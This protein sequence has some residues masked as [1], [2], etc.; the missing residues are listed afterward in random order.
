MF[1]LSFFAATLAWA[2]ECGAI[3]TEWL[4]CAKTRDCVII[5]DPC[6]WPKS[7]TN[8][9]FSAEA[10]KVN[11]CLA[12][13]LSCPAW[14][15]KRDGRWVAS[16]VKGSCSAVGA[17]GTPQGDCE[18]SGGRWEGS[19]SGRGRLTGCNMPTSDRGKPCARGE[20]CE[21]V[22]LNDGTCFGWQLYKGCALFKG[23]RQSICLE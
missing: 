17:P 10:Q 6:G 23:H 21:S 16:C 13:A 9:K 19:I 14:D 7:A 11:R 3:R 15:E 12:A 4:D 18:K 8:K 22:C 2:S 5:S 1:L 20:D